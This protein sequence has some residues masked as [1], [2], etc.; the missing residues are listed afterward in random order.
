MHEEAGLGVRISAPCSTIGAPTRPRV[1]MKN[2]GKKIPLVGLYN[3]M[4]NS[5]MMTRLVLLHIKLERRL[6]FVFLLISFLAM[7]HRLKT[8]DL[9]AR[10]L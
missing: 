1:G 3:L 5:C 9:Q 10:S 4:N 8:S 7:F 6:R 2:D